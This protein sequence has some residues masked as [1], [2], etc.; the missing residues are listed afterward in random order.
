MLRENGA[1]GV[2]R[3]VPGQALC[4]EARHRPDHRRKVLGDL[5]F[6]NHMEGRMEVGV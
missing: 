2:E 6:D 1:N 5:V 4:L 3:I